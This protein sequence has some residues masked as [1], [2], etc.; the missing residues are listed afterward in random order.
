MERRPLCWISVFLV[1]LLLASLACNVGGQTEPTATAPPPDPTATPP[2][3]PSPSPLP[4]PTAV[5]TATPLPESVAVSSLEDVRSATIQIVA[6]GSFVD[7]QVGLQ[8]NVAG[9]GSGFIIDESGIAVTNNHVVTGAALLRVW[10]GGESTPRNARVLGVSE[11]SDLAVI[12]IEGDEYPFLEWYEGEIRAGLDVYAA[13]YPLGDPEYT[14]TR[15]IVSKESADGESDWASVDA[16]I[17]HDATINPGSSGGPL[18]TV[19]GRVVGLNYSSSPGYNQYYAIARDEAKGI[20]EQLQAGHDVTSIG[21]NGT[22]VNEEGLSGIWVSSVES[23]SPADRAGIVGGDIITMIEGLVLATDGTMSSYC[24]ILRS[25]HA[26]DMLRIEVLRYDTEEVLEGYLNGDELTHSFSF[27]QELREEVGG[28]EA[29]PATSYAEYVEVTDDTGAIVMQVPVEWSDIDGSVWEDG[30]QTVGVGIVASS[31]LDDFHESY[32]TPGVIFLAAEGLAQAGDSAELLDFFDFSDDCWYEGRFDYEDALY[33][34]FY[35]FYSGCGGGDTVMIVLVAMPADRSFATVL[36]MQ[37]VTDADLDATD[38]ILDTF[39]VV[40]DLP[41]AGDWWQPDDEGVATAS[42]TVLNSTNQSIWYIYISPSSSESW[43]DD[44]LGDSVLVA[45]E[46]MT[47]SV[48]EGT[49]DLKALDP[50]D[51]VVA[52]SYDVFI[53]GNME[54]TIL[55][56]DAEDATLTVHNATTGSIWYVYISPSTSDSWGDDWL[57]DSVLLAG[58]SMEFSVPEGTYDLKALDPDDNVV[59]ERYDLFISGDMEWTLY[60]DDAEDDY[61]TLTLINNSGQHICYVRISESTDSSW[62]DDWLLA[63]TIPAG[64]SYSFYVPAGKSDDLQAK[65]CGD[66][67]VSVEYEVD[68]SEDT[69]WTVSAAPPP[70]GYAPLTF[71]ASWSTWPVGEGGEWIIGFDIQAQGGD[72]QYTYQVLDRVYYTSSFEFVYGCQADFTGDIVVR[73]GDG[74]VSMITQHIPV[75]TGC[76]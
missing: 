38:R 3:S 50:D 48:P 16:V 49:Y 59:A 64:T 27:A 37:A 58:E 2:P 69:D 55:P 75:P 12:D 63:D 26:D 24:D 8:L 28:D 20:I 56:E 35:D 7:P 13:G 4:P 60:L 42:L 36:A 31:D 15:G 5:P 41:D 47:F 46:S 40:G 25:H 17:E 33:D 29:G 51:N 57:G 43:G 1:M 30:G 61:V 11:C 74:Q 52:E 32:S 67:V 22:A 14:L 45:A 6:E 9:H 34:G 72:G 21:V 65:D 70:E 19:D 44:W 18:V 71:E 62:G 23:G 53:S 10:V 66:V 54:W 76:D 68:L 39:V 73:S